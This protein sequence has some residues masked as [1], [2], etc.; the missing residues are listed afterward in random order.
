MS[1]VRLLYLDWP[2]LHFRLAVETMRRRRGV[3]G[4]GGHRWPALGSGLVVDC[5]PPAAKLGVHRDQPLGTAHKLVPEAHFMAGDLEAA[6]S[7]FEAVLEALAEFTPSLEA[8]AEP[9]G[10][11]FGQVLLGI[12]GLH[13]LW[14]DERTL[15]GRL[16]SAVDAL[17]PGPLRIGIANTRFGAQVAPWSAG[18]GRRPRCGCGDA[19]RRPATWAPLPIR[20]LPADEL[21]RERLRMFG[22]TRIGE[23]A[24][25]PAR[26]SWRASARRASFFTN[27]RAAWTAGRCGPEADRASARGSGARAAGGRHSI[28]CASCCHNLCGALCEQLRARGAGADGRPHDAG[29]RA[30]AGPRPS[31]NSSCPS[32]RPRRT[33]WNGCSLRV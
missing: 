9:D 3:A 25:M 20:L 26:R 12:E 16:I 10:D 14:G 21:T 7:R 15:A 11:A 17:L 29:S 30:P 23:L 2:H 28:R 33:C 5:S 24:A 18:K 8:D 22:L 31:S 13:R 27:W 19:V 6:R 32:R 1:P 4:A